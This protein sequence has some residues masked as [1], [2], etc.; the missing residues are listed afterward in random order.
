LS[1]REL[2]RFDLHNT[3]A[4]L[5]GGAQ[6]SGG[7]AGGLLTTALQNLAGRRLWVLVNPAIPVRIRSV[8]CG[9]GATFSTPGNSTVAFLPAFQPQHS[10]WRSYGKPVT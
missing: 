1:K 4:P 10:T 2:R 9:G 7:R 3:R 8:A 6:S 5:P